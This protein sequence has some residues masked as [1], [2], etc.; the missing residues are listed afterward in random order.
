M[1]NFLTQND[2]A[3][4]NNILHFGGANIILNLAFDVN[5]KYISITSRKT[6]IIVDPYNI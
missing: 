2:I 5:I 4:K 1:F 6:Q 3:H